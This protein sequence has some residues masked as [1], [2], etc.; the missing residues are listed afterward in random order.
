MSAHHREN[1]SQGT[2]HHLHFI[3]EE[4]EVQSNLLRTHLSQSHSSLWLC[5]P[6]SSLITGTCKSGQ[7]IL[8]ANLDLDHHDP[9]LVPPQNENHKASV[10]SFS[11]SKID[12]A[13]G[14]SY[15]HEAVS[16]LLLMLNVYQEMTVTV[17]VG[18]CYFVNP[19]FF[20]YP[21]EK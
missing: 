4:S 13:E 20:F 10:V 5:G 11:K 1:S 8:R 6:F 17:D 14:S 16:F 18:C 9:F 2:W 15:F 12:S 3:E 21:L 7:G 19:F